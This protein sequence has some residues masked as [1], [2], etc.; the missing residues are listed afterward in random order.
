MEQTKGRWVQIGRAD[1]RDILLDITDPDADGAF[2]DRSEERRKKQNNEPF[3]REPRY[4]LTLVKYDKSK[5][6]GS[7][8]EETTHWLEENALLLLMHDI[9]SLRKGAEKEGTNGRK[10]REPICRDYKGSPEV[11][12]EG[13]PKV[14][15]SRSLTVKYND[16]LT[17]GPVYEFN[18][19]KC[20]GVANDQGAVEPKKGPDGKPAKVFYEGVIRVGTV[21]NKQGDFV[22]EMAMGV[23]E[24]IRAKKSAQLAQ[25][26]NQSTKSTPSYRERRQN[27]Y[28]RPA[29]QEA[30]ERNVA[31]PIGRQAPVTSHGNGRPPVAETAPVLAG[32][33]TIDD[34]QFDDPFSEANLVPPP[35]P[36]RGG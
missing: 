20:E 15:V 30:P 28:E 8:G 6:A 14:M 3:K 19:M 17:M 9:L 7:R 10:F 35:P 4:A 16:G 27:N 22:R 1:S 36:S 25:F 31:P 11:I 21:G 26:R 34:G 23:I 12:E 2:W 13:K 18:F 33:A 24:Y 29:P 32:P 5:P